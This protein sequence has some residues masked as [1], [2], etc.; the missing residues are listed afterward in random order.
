MKKLF[1][2]LCLFAGANAYGQ[3]IA[4]KSNLLYDLTTTINL[5]AEVA[6]GRQWT[7]DVSGNYNP[8]SRSL[9]DVVQPGNKTI[10]Y[11]SQL[12]HWMVQPE[13]RW[14]ACEA[15]HGHY[16]GLHGHYGQ[17]DAGGLSLLPDGIADG[18]TDHR[19]THADGLKHKRFEGMAVGAG[20]AYGYHWILSNRF[21]LEFSI[22]AGYAWMDYHK[23]GKAND[24]LEESHIQ[25]FYV[26]PTRLG[27]SAVFMLY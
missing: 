12:K 18:F 21:S 25:T 27:I 14:W 2:M 4:V 20:L 16:F 8:W 3:H 26:G 23:F 10:H 11:K 24:A 22:G 1:L 7:I 13:L 6:V 19:G 9:T 17:F 15:F 5:G